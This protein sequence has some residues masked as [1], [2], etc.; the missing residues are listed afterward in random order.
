MNTKRL[1]VLGIALVAASGAAL[2]VRG[3]MGGG[4]PRVEARIAPQIAMSQVL[5]ANTALQPGQPLSADQVR[6]EKWPASSVDSSFITQDAVS[7]VDDAV[8]GTVVRMPIVSGQPITNTEI[9]HANAA[10]FMAAMLNPGMRA[11]SITITA[12]S[13]A[14][15]FILPNDRID[16]I[17]T[18][19]TGGE[20][21]HVRARTILQ[22][23]R[24]LAVDQTFKQDKDTKT[25]IAKT[26]TLE[27]TPAQAEQVARAQNQGTLSLSLRPLGDDGASAGATTT[28]VA[29]ATSGTRRGANG[30]GAA[31]AINSAL[32]STGQDNG[33]DDADATGDSVS[34]IRYGIS[35]DAKPS[36]EKAQ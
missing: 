36:Q 9:V 28:A 7:S 20:V 2:L 13:G 34:I 5:V 27:L 26:A 12:D 6:W 23:V 4:T 16:L 17:L 18:Q 22:N 33:D 35:H 21:A 29:S 32:N 14:G 19:K 10:G 8:K 11:V 15:G 31:D 30:S 25:V 3:M 24:V 1:V